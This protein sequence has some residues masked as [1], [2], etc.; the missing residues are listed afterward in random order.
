MK[1]NTV[2]LPGEGYDI[3]FCP[4]CGG[5]TGCVDSNADPARGWFKRYRKC[6]ECGKTTTTVELIMLPG[7]S[8]KLRPAHVVL[9]LED[10]G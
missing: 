2:E 3:R 7:K 6:R 9:G 10:E 1:M 4:V 5:K 8:G